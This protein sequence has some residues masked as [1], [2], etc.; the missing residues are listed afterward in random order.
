MLYIYIYILF[1]MLVLFW[2]VLHCH[3]HY[4]KNDYNINCIA[5]IT[6]FI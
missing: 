1:E 5:Y 3:G 6:G 2:M 4:K